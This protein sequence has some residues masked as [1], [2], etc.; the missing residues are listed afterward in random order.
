MGNAPIDFDGETSKVQRGHIPAPV[1][2]E[3]QMAHCS[4]PYELTMEEC[5]E[6]GGGRMAM[7]S[8]IVQLIWDGS[9]A[10]ISLDRNA[11]RELGMI[12]DTPAA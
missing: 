7:L 8:S 9:R 4:E 5:E 2:E 10:L 11:G 12:S 1:R 6:V 3:S